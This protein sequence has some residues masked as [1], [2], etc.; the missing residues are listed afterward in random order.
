VPGD[1]GEGTG[2]VVAVAQL[3]AAIE[4]PAAET[5]AG[6]ADAAKLVANAPATDAERLQKRVVLKAD[7][8]RVE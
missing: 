6:L 4:Q 1:P 3:R 7:G 5:A 2:T 8:C